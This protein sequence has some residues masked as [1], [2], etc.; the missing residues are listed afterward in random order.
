MTQRAIEAEGR[1]ALKWGI[2]AVSMTRP[3]V[4]NQLRPQDGLYTAL[5]RSAQGVKAEI[6]GTLNEIVHAPSDAVGLPRRIASPTTEIVTLTVTPTGYLLE[7]TTGRLQESHRDI[8][9]DLRHPERP[10]SAVGAIAAGLAQIHAAGRKPPVFISCDNVSENGRTLQ[11]A[12]A[13]FAA[14]RDDK[15]ASWIESHVTFPGTMVDRIVPTLT[16]ADHEDAER[17]TGLQDAAPVSMEPFAQWIIE[18]FQ[19]ARPRWDLAGARFVADARPFELAK[20]RLLNGTH[21]LLAY[22]GGLAGYKTIADTMS[23]PLFAAFAESFMLREQGMTLSMS[24]TELSGYVAQL[25]ERL[26]NP[27]IRHDV[28]RIGRNGSTKMATRLVRPLRENLSAG[29]ATPCAIL[30]MAAWI[31]WFAPQGPKAPHLHV[32]DP[33]KDAL[34][35]LFNE[36]AADPLLQARRFLAQTEIFGPELPDHETIVQQLAASLEDLAKLP[37]REVLRRRLL[38]QRGHTAL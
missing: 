7:P 27:A 33:R 30:T 2:A 10:R 36:T 12:V 13:N 11:R 17:L 14:L 37:V 15:L 19:G 34:S 29:R 25:T 38:S 32:T 26:C 9:H 28:S 18:D 16:H 1:N 4:P 20:L 6:I 21:M 35:A 22:L 24:P 5:E 3:T 8:Q 23:D 31:R